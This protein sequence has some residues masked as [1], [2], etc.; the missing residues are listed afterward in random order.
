MSML[1]FLS[2]FNK[3]VVQVKHYD[4]LKHLLRLAAF[5]IFKQG[6]YNSM[7]L[8]GVCMCFCYF[9]GVFS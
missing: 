1:L 6:E 8:F 4:L 2:D 9:G 3:N 7:G 5:G